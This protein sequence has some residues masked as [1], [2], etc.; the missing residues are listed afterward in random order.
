MDYSR[1]NIIVNNV[2]E[3]PM[4][5]CVAYLLFSVPVAILTFIIETF[6]T[7]E[8]LAR[9]GVCLDDLHKLTTA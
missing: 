4:L 9:M 3:V 7:K 6:F 8:D 2:L 5:T 1:Q